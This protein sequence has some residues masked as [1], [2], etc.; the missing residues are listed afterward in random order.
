MERNAKF[1]GNIEERVAAKLNRL[2]DLPGLQRVSDN[3]T[4]ETRAV[5]A[6]DS[7]GFSTSGI[8]RITIGATRS[9]MVEG[10]PEDVKAIK[11]EVRD[12]TLYIDSGDYGFDRHRSGPV[13]VHV[14]MP[15]L[16]GVNFSGS[17]KLYMAGLKGGKTD[18]KLS[19]S[20]NI[21]A[22]GALDELALKISGSGNANIP[23]LIIGDAEVN[24]SGSGNVTLQPRKNLNVSISGSGNVRYVGNPAHVDVSVSGSGSVRRRDET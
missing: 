13:T 10:R 21:E 12:N 1:A 3:S 5:A 14:T 18:V 9:V 23:D 4:Q 20:G 24:L 2:Q 15:S 7:V 22:S 11:T 17:G 8:L 19:G 16:K 6:F